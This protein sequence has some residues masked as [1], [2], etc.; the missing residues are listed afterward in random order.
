APQ[1]RLVGARVQHR[2]DGERHS[3]LHHG[4]GAGI[5]EVRD[6][7]PGVERGADAMPGE[8]THH[9]VAEPFGVGLDHPADDVELSSGCDRLDAAV[10]RRTGALDQVSDLGGDVTDAEGRVRV[11]V[12]AVKV[13][14]DVDVDDVTLAEH[15]RVGDAVADHLVDAGTQRLGE[16]AVLQRRWVGA[17]VEQVAVSDRVELVGGD[18][19]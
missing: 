3:R 18:T 2:L 8:L 15:G 19:R 13:G 14:G 10:H 12:H 17:V 11:P 16:T 9:A 5:V 6:D 7:Q 4:G 1:V